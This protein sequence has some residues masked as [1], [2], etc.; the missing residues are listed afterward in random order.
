MLY[1]GVCYGVC[2]LLSGSHVAA[3]LTNGSL[4]FGV[5]VAMPH[6]YGVYPWQ[7]CMPIDDGL[8]PMPRLH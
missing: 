6:P 7:L 3:M 2:F 8:W 5:K 1:V 4:T